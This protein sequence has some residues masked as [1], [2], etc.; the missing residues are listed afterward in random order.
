MYMISF[1]LMAVFNSCLVKFLSF[2][3]QPREAV[4]SGYNKP[5]HH[6]CRQDMPSI[7]VDQQREP[8]FLRITDT[9]LHNTGLWGGE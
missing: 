4:W 1:M 2:N 3:A 6:L 7:C 9:I 5:L 8:R